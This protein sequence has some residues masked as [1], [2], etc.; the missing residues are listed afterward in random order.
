MSVYIVL[1]IV[2]VI[3]TSVLCAMTSPPSISS[4]SRIVNIPYLPIK[5]ELFEKIKTFTESEAVYILNCHE[6]LEGIKDNYYKWS[7]QADEERLQRGRTTNST[8]LWIISILFPPAIFIIREVGYLGSLEVVLFLAVVF[9][10][11]FF[12][13]RL[14]GKLNHRT[15]EYPDPIHISTAVEGRK[16]FDTT[17][18]FKELDLYYKESLERT[19]DMEECISLWK[20]GPGEATIKN[21]GAV[22]VAVAAVFVVL[23]ILT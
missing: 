4:E 19:A 20:A 17:N 6:K 14:F 22:L 23:L 9:G 3:V 18:T 13:S 2:W 8:V 7:K 10:I 21:N 11:W 16:R 15:P 12:V 5:T 1:A